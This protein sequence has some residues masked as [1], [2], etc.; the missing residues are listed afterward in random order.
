MPEASYAE[1][2][3]Y[4]TD[5]VLQKLEKKKGLAPQSTAAA[6]VTPP[7]PSGQ[8]VH[9]PLALQRSV[10]SKSQGQC[11]ATTHQKRCSS[12]YRL[13]IDHK[14]PLALGG[15]NDPANLRIL[16]FHHNQLQARA[17]LRPKA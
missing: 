7:L 12:R 1:L 9:L 14:M 13:Q 16:C 17:L 11:E 8:R 4:M 10:W 2:L 6:A 15:S 5:E 3:E